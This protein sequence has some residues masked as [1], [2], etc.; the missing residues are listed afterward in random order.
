MA[1]QPGPGLALDHG[2]AAVPLSRL[3]GADPLPPYV[4][5]IHDALTATGR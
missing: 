4:R 3:P 5:L 2:T 1:K